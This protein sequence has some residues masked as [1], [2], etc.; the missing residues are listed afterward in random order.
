MASK[1][2]IWNMAL[3]QLGNTD[4]VVADT[5]TTAV[6]TTCALFWDT[7]LDDVLRAV[8]WPFATKFVALAGKAAAPNID[9]G[10]SYT[11]PADCVTARRILDTATRSASSVTKI[12]MRARPYDKIFTDIDNATLEYTERVTDTTKWPADFVAC[13]ALLLAYRVSPAI[14]GGEQW[15]LADR[16]LAQYEKKI[17]EAAAN[18]SAEE[19]E[20]PT[21]IV[22]GSN[23]K[24]DIANAALAFLGVD[25]EI[26]SLASEKTL[27]A[28]TARQYYDKTRDDVLR[29]FD[30]AFATKYVALGT[31]VASPNT[32]WA[33]SYAV[34]ADCVKIRKILDGAGRV[35][36]MQS[37]VPFKRATGD[38]VFTSVDNAIV[39]YTMRHDTPSTYPADFS[40]LFG[41]KLAM[42]MGP[43]MLKTAERD[44]VL[45]ELS[46]MYQAAF[47]DTV[48][49]AA[50]EERDVSPETL[51]ASK[52]AEDICNA[53]LSL[54]GV[55]AEI[56][57]LTTELTREARALRQF[58]S[59]AVDQVLRDFDWGFARKTAT[60]ALVTADPTEEWL[61]AYTIPADCVSIR[62][63]LDGS[64]TR[65]ETETSRRQ[66]IIAS[67]NAVPVI[68][69]DR[70]TAV[71]QYT[72]RVADPLL[73]P[74]DFITA[75]SAY[76]AFKVA[77]K[78]VPPKERSAAQAA[79]WAQYTQALAQ[80]QISSA[81]EEVPELESDSSL[82]RSRS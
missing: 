30:W 74:S 24:E 43:R 69:T 80:A 73:F 13:V 65:A 75:L 27:A 62:R 18:A 45:K 77:P 79:A 21:E 55:D 38:L 10:F 63:I 53:A 46:V 15:K 37:R 59:K 61:F 29:M 67:H 41:L 33:F 4:V 57:T 66:F 1:V 31:K 36:A 3:A 60:L 16:A 71:A 44:G 17:Q 25:Y 35:P 76:L 54:L 68:F 12:P 8:A 78:L 81:T 26:R 22:V 28:R 23:P 50:L 11:Y 40:L 56:Q 58:Y 20:Y 2:N 64:G 47:K 9:W 7:T 39:E 72:L 70:E 82:E 49:S 6:A 5:D 14:A 51:A 34:P 48:T 52:P 42:R 32:E 19:R